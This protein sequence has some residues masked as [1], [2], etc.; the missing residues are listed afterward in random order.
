MKNPD[1]QPR[2]DENEETPKSKKQEA[3][4]A[5][6]AAEGKGS[7]LKYEFKISPADPKNSLDFED[8]ADK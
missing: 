3:P 6:A 1:K 8:V 4:T 7:G 2:K 5:D